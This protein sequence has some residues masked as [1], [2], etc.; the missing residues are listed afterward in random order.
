LIGTNGL[1]VEGAYT[2]GNNMRG[3][4]LEC[5]AIPELKVHAIKVAQLLSGE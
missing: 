2:I 1:P 3:T 4:L 5:T